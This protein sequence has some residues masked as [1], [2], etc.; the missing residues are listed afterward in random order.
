[1]FINFGDNRFLDAQG[2]AP[3]GEVTK[4]MAVVDSFYSGYGEKPEQNR[5]VAEGNAYLDSQFPKLWCPPGGI[6]VS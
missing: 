6:N 1:M 4:G 3:V 5:I 2:F